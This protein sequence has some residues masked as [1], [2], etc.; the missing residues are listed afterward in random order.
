M[1]LLEN[2]GLEPIGRTKKKSMED[3]IMFYK[4]DGSY[5]SFTLQGLLRRE[6]LNWNGFDAAWS[7]QHGGLVIA[8]GTTFK[9]RKDQRVSSK[10]VCDNIVR[11]YKITF[12]DHAGIKAEFQAN[13]LSTDVYVLKLLQVSE[14]KGRK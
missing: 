5:S 12:G 14:L 8:K 3:A 13:A 11:F 10:D 7:P 1:S 4:K 2:F 9:F 6:N